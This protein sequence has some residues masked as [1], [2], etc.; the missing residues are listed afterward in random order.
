MGKL[1]PFFH[2][3]NEFA[4]QKRIIWYD[5]ES[6]KNYLYF[7]KSIFV[8]YKN[9]SDWCVQQHSQAVAEPAGGPARD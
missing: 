5:A 8:F 4:I 6:R 3:K 1:I 9:I 2:F 7:E